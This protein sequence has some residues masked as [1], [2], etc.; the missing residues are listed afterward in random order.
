MK[1]TIETRAGKFVM[2]DWEF[3]SAFVKYANKEPVESLGIGHVVQN[4]LS[5]YEEESLTCEE[6]EAKGRGCE[7]CEN[8]E[9][10]K[11]GDV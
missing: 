11:T 9:E 8:K 5:T 1:I 2:K 10:V 3:M 6:A 4:F 7:E